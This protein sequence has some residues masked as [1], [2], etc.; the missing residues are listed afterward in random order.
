MSMPVVPPR[1]SRPQD[2]S[3]SQTDGDAPLVPPRP[4][5]SSDRSKSRSREPYARSP[6][7]DPQ[8]TTSI[9]STELGR[10]NGS[11]H[12][13]A[14]PGLPRAP[15]VS[16]LPMIGQEGM[17]YASLEDSLAKQFSSKDEAQSPSETRNV[18]SDLP[19]HAP[20]ASASPIAA[21]QRI[22]QVTRT[23]SSKAAV[24]GVGK[25]HTDYEPPNRSE[26]PTE[27]AR[28]SSTYS[29]E[30]PSSAQESSVDPEQEHGIPEIGLQVPMNPMAGDVQ[31]PTPG[32]STDPLS[33]GVGFFNNAATP[34][35]S[36]RRS[37]QGF[38]VPPGSYGLHGHGV[39]P[40][41]KFEQAWYQKHPDERAKE[42]Y[43]AYGPALSSERPE[44]AMSSD[45]LNK[46]VHERAGQG[47][48]MG[49]SP[50]AIGQP[51]E[52]VG[53]QVSAEYASRMHSPQ[54]DS[55]SSKK[56]TSRTSS[57]THAESPL[58]RASF[59]DDDMRSGN[60]LE[61]EGDDDHF[62]VK[63]P[64]R[65][66]EKV[67]GA[68]YDPP[69]EDLGPEGGNTDEQ[70][71]WIHERGVGTPILASD[72]IKKHPAAEY[73]QPAVSPAQ[74]LR[75]DDYNQSGGDSDHVPT[76]HSRKKSSGSRSRPSSR[77]T[78]LHSHHGLSRFISQD[79]AGTGTPLEE[80]EEY[81]PLF[82]DDEKD[83]GRKPVT[84]A[85]KMRKRPD[86]DSHRFPS[87]DIWE[88]TPTS[89][90]LHTTVETPEQE[91]AK[92]V[93]SQ[94]GK[95]AAA[96]FESPEKELARK[97]EITEPE[98]LDF[99]SDPTTG[100]AKPKF[101]ERLQHE[102]DGHGR[103]GLGVRFPSQDVWEDTPDSLRLETTVGEQMEAQ[104]VSTA[105]SVP[106]RPTRSKEEG[107]GSQPSIPPRPQRIKPKQAE[108][109]SPTGDQQG[110][111]IPAKA[112]PQIPPRPGRTK[113]ETGI[114]AEPP[115]STAE[116][117]AKAKPAVPARP[118]AGSSK[119][120]SI[121]AGF[122]NDL[123]NRLQRGPEAEKPV[124]EHK[125]IQAEEKLPLNDARKGRAR[126]PARRK[127][128]S[129]P[130]PLAESVMTPAQAAKP[131][132]TIS[133]PQTLW[134]ISD[135]GEF[136]V[137]V[138]EITPTPAGGTALS[139]KTTA[140]SLSEIPT[141]SPLARNT[142]GES[143]QPRSET[144]KISAGALASPANAEADARAR[145]EES[146]VK[147]SLQEFEVQRIGHAG[148]VP[149]VP[150]V[151]D[152]TGAS[153][154]TEAAADEKPTA[155]TTIARSETKNEEK[156]SAPPIGETEAQ[157]E[158]IG[159]PLAPQASDYKTSPASDETAKE[160]LDKEEQRLSAPEEQV[161]GVTGKG[162][163]T[164][165][166]GVQGA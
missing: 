143:L 77:P 89:L 94:G 74:Q 111:G 149:E 23:D 122:M 41:D 153:A 146:G 37:A 126:G 1:P 45:E 164:G 88:D 40:Q 80:I 147:K 128:A 125:T 102:D 8:S 103:P 113:P 163:D 57:Q 165:A 115:A 47:P 25:A 27:H 140:Q 133:K 104:K 123:N 20:K 127:P 100:L 137:L 105:P 67:G 156:E 120:A 15:S 158:D 131:T 99:L 71:G 78:S 107:A 51:P 144:P 75:E 84:V 119:F 87:K 58:R 73:M 64:P 129:S 24:A 148:D 16:S 44:W 62:H 43:G 33:T 95:S 34:Q 76:Y 92:A 141:A 124:E 152:D 13:S 17:E 130:S 97:G 79:E 135:S 63:P 139:R 132:L 50:S 116:L 134:S 21:K 55:F 2:K 110:P 30:R 4:A 48:A 85:D 86:L 22:A 18:A 49:A 69:T 138:P 159:A 31:A 70:G 26:I 65:R 60:A 61:S 9:P 114:T 39:G 101:K 108:A 54:L 66:V 46:L 56:R 136:D 14:G 53:Y 151:G 154:A 19:L 52:A 83:A 121:K 98:R 157:K 142:A 6:L 117:P 112:K 7:N 118:A 35:E 91:A 28:P 12:A 59:A 38:H 162:S 90:Q 11:S 42:E 166:D 160:V 109:V 68:G 5:R 93:Q 145:D 10:L 32:P 72:E 81:E 3:P 82:K 155:N 161:A 96:A 36:R 106:A 29:T 150:D